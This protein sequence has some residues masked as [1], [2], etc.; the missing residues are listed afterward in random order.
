MCV[1][2]LIAK[3][4]KVATGV[5][6]LAVFKMRKVQHG[7][8]FPKR[9]SFILIDMIRHFSYLLFVSFKHILRCVKVTFQSIFRLVHYS[10]LNYRHI[11]IVISLY[12][13]IYICHATLSSFFVLFRCPAVKAI[14]YSLHDILFAK[15][16]TAW[17][18]ESLC[19]CFNYWKVSS[20]KAVNTHALTSRHP[21]PKHTH[22]K[23]EM[24]ILSCARLSNQIFAA[25][26]ALLTFI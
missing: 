13:Y 11:I 20:F 18:G 8:N 9:G 21:T 3:R 6:S 14:E 2:L 23:T 4:G 19:A 1:Q 25:W 16:L 15:L 17:A 12:L 7:P 24:I 26:I 5:L 10:K 22:P